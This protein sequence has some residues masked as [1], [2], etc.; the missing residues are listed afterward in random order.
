[1]T[2]KTL[3]KDAFVVS[4]KFSTRLNRRNSML[5]RILIPFADTYSYFYMHL[6]SNRLLD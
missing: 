6:P 5:P 1:M 4:L 2:L 3:L